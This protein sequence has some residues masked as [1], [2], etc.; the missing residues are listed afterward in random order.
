MD[1]GNGITQG[2]L[3]LLGLADTGKEQRAGSPSL[4][5]GS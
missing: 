1:L 2:G 5:L 4:S 3:G